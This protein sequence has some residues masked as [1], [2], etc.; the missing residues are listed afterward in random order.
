MQNNI[1]K[2]EYGNIDELR[3]PFQE[4]FDYI[5]FGDVLE[6]LMNPEEVLRKLRKYLKTGGHI[7]ISMPNVK[8]YSVLLPLLRWDVFHM[9][10][11]VSWIGRM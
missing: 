4:K 1:T 8:H 9:V 11:P 6:H 2:A 3:V 10:I 5:I 7:I